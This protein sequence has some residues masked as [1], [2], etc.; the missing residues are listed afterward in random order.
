MSGSDI[1]FRIAVVAAA[2]ALA[3]AIAALRFC[4]RMS[5]PAKPPAPVAAN[6]GAPHAP[7]RS[8]S[9]DVYLEHVARDAAAAG[10]RAPSL[11][12]MARKLPYR[13]DSTRHVLEVGQPALA[14]AG[15][16]LRALRSGDSLALEITSASAS[17]L[18]YDVETEPIPA[19][20]CNAAQPL[21][22]NA[23]T[24]GPGGSETRTECMWRDGIALAV[25]RVETLEVSPL[26]AWYLGRVP[27]AIVGVAPR[28]ARGHRGSSATP[29]CRN[30]LP[31]AVRSGL[32]RGEIGW[33]DLVDFYARHPCDAYQFP[34]GYQAF[35]TDGERTVPA[36]PAG[37]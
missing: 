21:P 11:V 33:R 27:P 10:L 4:G 25:T 20:R 22:F 6:P 32:E 37:M 13:V 1:R 9:P 34:V 26:S 7:W 12:E 14:I 30:I 3:C 15:V 16:R 5:L 35:K 23:M 17:D 19:V 8:S 31:Q 24:L 29:P 36:A 2:V 18:A 28:V